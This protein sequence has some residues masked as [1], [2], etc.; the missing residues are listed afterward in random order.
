MGLGKRIWTLWQLRPSVVA[1]ALLAAVVALWSVADIGLAPP[2]LK[3]RALEM[4]TATT[5]VVVDTPRSSVLDLRQ[6][7]YSLEA[8]TQ[9]GVLLGNVIA[10]GSVRESIARRAH[11]PVDRLQ[12]TAPFTPKQPRAEGGTAT[13]KRTGDLL[14]STDQY[15][16]TIEANSTVPLL[17]IY[18]Q[19]PTAESAEL[20]ANATVNG[21]QAYLT[22][23]AASQQIPNSEQIRLLQLGRARGTVINK[24]I[25]W[26]VCFLAFVLTF[27]FACA[28]SI[29]FS[30][31]GQGWRLAALADQR[32]GA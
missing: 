6:N 4:A 16:I 24:G 29:Y 5:H 12:I 27:A 18:S 8:L 13:K 10:N 21:L 15:R 23:L 31:V 25:D 11:V 3:P 26:Q 14:K 30:R 1:S 22:G 7:T 9:R 32:A 17:D 28:T 2:H 20:L 19:A